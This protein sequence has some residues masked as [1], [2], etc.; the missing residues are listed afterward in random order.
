MSEKILHSITA[1]FDTPDDII[2]AAEKVSEKGYK[3]YDVNTPYPVHG[4][5]H[6]MK[7]PPSKLG[8]FALVFGLTGTFTALALM[9]WM[10]VIDY[11]Q[12][13]GG[14]PFFPFPAY[15][16]VMF[17]VTVL[18]ASIATVMSML[19][20]FFKFP[21]NK[22][23]LHD[24]EYMKKVSVDKFGVSIEAKDKLFN[25]VDVKAF[26]AEIGGKEITPVYY[27]NEEINHKNVILEPKFLGFLLVT[28]IIVSGATYF[29][30]NKLLFM[31]PFDW[32]MHQEKVIAQDD[33]SFYGENRAM[34][35]P[36]AGTVSRNN[37]PYLYIG[38][39]EEAAVAMV[40]PLL[41]SKENLKLGEEKYNTYCSP[42]HGYFGEGDSRLR[43]QFPN[44]PSLH[45]EKVRNW[46]DGRIYHVIMEGQNV[47]PSYSS[48]MTREER[49][50]SIL[51]L[52]ALQRSL[53]AKETDLQ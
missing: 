44:P 27:D 26:L 43:G 11:P 49:W 33:F 29:T 39:P 19:I 22:H 25:E 7:L 3:D 16:P 17:E 42:C 52:R 20:V 50:A 15:V 28:F 2:H 40:N 45:S 32:M 1:I 14:K 18:S 8:Y 30:M 31:T 35:T 34:L 10:S 53:N 38:K 36:V 51:Y 37:L 12:V 13:I 41:P 24:S 6:A 9:F 46:S 48:L 5:D 21:N 47:M 4:M 23:P